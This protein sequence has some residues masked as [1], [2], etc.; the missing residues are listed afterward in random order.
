VDG[1]PV[2]GFTALPVDSGSSDYYEG[3]VAMPNYSGLG[4]LRLDVENTLV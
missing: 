4:Y 3:S 1:F 2:S